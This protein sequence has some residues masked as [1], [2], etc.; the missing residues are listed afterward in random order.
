MDSVQKHNIL[1]HF[2]VPFSTKQLL[3]SIKCLSVKLIK[4]L[5]SFIER[6]VEREMVEPVT[7]DTK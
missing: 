1:H 3:H 4:G 6:R 5:I 2:V 7:F